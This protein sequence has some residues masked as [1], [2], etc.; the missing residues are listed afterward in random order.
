MLSVWYE[1]LIEFPDIHL[2]IRIV[3]NYITFL[4]HAGTLLSNLIRNSRK[5]DWN[6]FNY[7]IV[8]MQV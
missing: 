2:N 8:N 4:S 3:S 6:L 1:R 5:N 7:Y